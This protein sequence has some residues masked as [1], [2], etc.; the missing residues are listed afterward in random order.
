MPFK[1]FKT[2]VWGLRRKTTGF[3]FY[4]QIIILVLVI[5]MIPLGGLSIWL[6]D[7]NDSALRKQ[8]AN[9]EEDVLRAT[10]KATWQE[11]RLR[12]EQATFLQR[13]F[14]AQSQPS[15]TDTVLSKKTLGASRIHLVVFGAM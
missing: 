5:V 10:L 12:Q 4:Q 15:T 7:I 6:Y 11:A 13:A 14:I 1:L 2:K 3:R 8:I 9:T